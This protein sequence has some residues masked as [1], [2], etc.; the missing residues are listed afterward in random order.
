[1][2]AFGQARFSIVRRYCRTSIS[3]LMVF[4]SWLRLN[5]FGEKR[6]QFELTAFEQSS[7]SAAVPRESA[8]A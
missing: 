8:R 2:L 5:R 7:F 6:T 4:E 3:V 1:M